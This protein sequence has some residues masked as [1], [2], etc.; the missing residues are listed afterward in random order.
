MFLIES[1]FYLAAILCVALSAPPALTIT[2]L[3]IAWFY[4]GAVHGNYRAEIHNWQFEL[5]MQ[6][7]RLWQR[8]ADLRE[9]LRRIYDIRHR[10]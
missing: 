5:K 8:V 9:R 3:I 7:S 4:C 6:K 10:G 2:I 1:F